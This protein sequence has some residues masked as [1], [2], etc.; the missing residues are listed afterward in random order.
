MADETYRNPVSFRTKG[1]LRLSRA[2]R[3]KDDMPVMF[4]SLAETNLT[5]SG[6]TRFLNEY[7]TIK[8]FSHNGI[9]HGDYVK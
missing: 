3:I 8:S 7:E 9:E 1:P 5:P 6:L 2:A 4:C